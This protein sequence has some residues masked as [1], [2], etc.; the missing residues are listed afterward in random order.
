MPALA[1]AIQDGVKALGTEGRLVVRYSGTEPLL[2]ILA[3][4][5]DKA[6]L[7]KVVGAV[8]QAA[9]VLA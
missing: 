8:A 4:G 9:G 1:L 5:P 2:R 6:L 7:E 3:E